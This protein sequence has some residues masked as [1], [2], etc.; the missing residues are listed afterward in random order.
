MGKQEKRKGHSRSRMDSGQHR[1]ILG[2][3][4]L[5]GL[6]AFLPVGIPAGEVK[7]PKKLPFAQRAWLNGFGKP[8]E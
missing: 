2:V 3:M 8:V 6:V 7:P 5:F 4:A 1:R